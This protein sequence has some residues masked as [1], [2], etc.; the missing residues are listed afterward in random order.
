[1]RDF[2]VVL[3]LALALAAATSAAPWSTISESAFIRVGDAGIG[4][5]CMCLMDRGRL[6]AAAGVV[7]P[8]P[9]LGPSPPPAAPVLTIVL[10]TVLAP[11]LAVSVPLTIVMFV[12][13]L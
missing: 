2:C 11:A 8:A 6:F 10:A 7:P 3:A 9:F 13:L 5:E 4:A 12:L 1:M